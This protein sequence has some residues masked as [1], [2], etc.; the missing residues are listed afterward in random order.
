MELVYLHE[1]VLTSKQIHS[2]LTYV[3]IPNTF[4]G[5]N[6]INIA[7]TIQHFQVHEPVH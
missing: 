1:K 6:A 5:A 3:V 2:F 4:N 7:K